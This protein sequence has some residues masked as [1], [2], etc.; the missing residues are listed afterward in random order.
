MVAVVE[1]DNP[2]DIRQLSCGFLQDENSWIFFPATVA[3]YTSEDGEHF[4]L[5][6]TANPSMGPKESGVHVE[7]I[8]VKSKPVKAKYIKVEA[9][10]LIK[11]PD[12]HNG[13]MYDGKAWLFADEIKIN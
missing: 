7:D 5:Y 13:A 4:T 1:M 3:F 12:W 9:K 11:C 2:K 10:S 6:G 8:T